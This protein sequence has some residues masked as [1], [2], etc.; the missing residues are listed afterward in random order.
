VPPSEVQYARKNSSAKAQHRKAAFQICMYITINPE[1]TSPP[2]RS[3]LLYIIAART[4]DAQYTTAR[5]NA[6]RETSLHMYSILRSLIY[7]HLSHALYFQYSTPLFFDGT[8]VRLVIVLG[9]HR[10]GRVGQGGDIDGAVVYGL[11]LQMFPVLADLGENGATVDHKVDVGNRLWGPLH[12][13][14]KTRVAGVQE[15]MSL[16]AAGYF[17]DV[18]VRVLCHKLEHV[19]ADIVAAES[20]QAPIGG[21]GGNF[22]VVVVEVGVFGSVEVLGDSATEKD[23]E[24]TI[25]F[26]EGVVLVEG[27]EDEGALHEVLVLE[28]GLKKVAGP[29]A[30]HGDRGVVS[31]GGHV[32]CDETPLRQ[33]LRL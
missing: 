30:S 2:K 18:V 11:V 3:F 20:V 19:G 6:E 9:V 31:V 8:L 14:V 12:G 5:S 29:F 26:G 7:N 13:V 4:V 23:A 10:L 21:D 17:P 25:L 32:W 16:K 15:H 28:Q 33:A 24:N 27:D 22:G 1:R